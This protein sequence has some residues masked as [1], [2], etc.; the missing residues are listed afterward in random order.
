MERNM[1]KLSEA[2]TDAARHNAIA[3]WGKVCD[4]SLRRYFDAT[5]S[6]QEATLKSQYAF[7]EAAGQ[8]L[9]AG[10]KVM[11]ENV[12]HLTNGTGKRKPS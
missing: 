3:R 7:L 4:A 5:R 12:E 11:T 1:R 9:A 2:N 10:N 6:L 8:M